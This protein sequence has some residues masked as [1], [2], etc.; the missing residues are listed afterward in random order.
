MSINKVMRQRG[1]NW[2]G[3]IFRESVND[4]F[5]YSI[6]IDSWRSEGERKTKNY[7]E[8]NS[9][10]RAKQ[11]GMEELRSS[12]SG[13]IRQK[14]LVRQRGGLMRLLVWWDMMMVKRENAFID[15]FSILLINCLRKCSWRSVKNLLCLDA[16][17]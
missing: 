13:C 14:V 10:E 3:H 8:K 2:L 5:K 12:Q 15:L 11:S 6:M 1:W 4:C 17:A 7:L 9:W 16:G